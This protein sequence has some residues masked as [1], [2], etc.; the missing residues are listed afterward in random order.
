MICLI[1]AQKKI[2]L[3]ADFFLSRRDTRIALVKEVINLSAFADC[4]TGYAENR[5]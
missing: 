1:I 5:D 4:L 3:G 2:R